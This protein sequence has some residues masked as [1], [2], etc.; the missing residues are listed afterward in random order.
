MTQ[1]PCCAL[2]VVALTAAGCGGDDDET[3]ARPGAPARSDRDPLDESP[4]PTRSAPTAATTIDQASP[5]FADGQP[6][7]QAIEQF[8]DETWS[9]ACSS[10][11][12]DR[13]SARSPEG[14]E[15]E[16]S[17]IRTLPSGAS[18]ARG[19]PPAR[20][21]P[22]GG[23]R[24]RSPRPTSSPRLRRPIE[25]RRRCCGRCAERARPRPD[26]RP[27]RLDRRAR[28]AGPR[29]PRRPGST[30]SGRSSCFRSSLTQ[31]MWL[32]AQT[33]TDRRRR[34]GS[35]GRSPAAR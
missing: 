9:R 18:R 35:P 8:V 20:G 11:G 16:S 5:E 24:R 4:R 10:R 34:P 32:A 14:D 33:E 21:R 26:R 23:Q 13:R 22:R 19:R 17:A 25:S 27:R 12:R 15:G 31:A 1:R 7:E 29:P 30:A 3:T 28:R 2:A 6:D